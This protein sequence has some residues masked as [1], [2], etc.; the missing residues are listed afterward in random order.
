[1][2]GDRDDEDWPD[3]E[4]NFA[5]LAANP[6]TILDLVQAVA[7]ARQKEQERPTDEELAALGKLVRDL[8]AYIGKQASTPD[9]DRDALLLH[10]RQL[11]GLT[12]I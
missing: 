8:V 2:E 4:S 10:A 1:M 6:L 7:A 9:P 11:L 12:G 5:V 3:I